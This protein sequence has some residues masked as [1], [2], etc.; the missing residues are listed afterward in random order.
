M[1]P[2]FKS[3]IEMCASFD[4]RAHLPALIVV[5][6]LAKYAKFVKYPNLLLFWCGRP[7]RTRDCANT[8]VG[9][10]AYTKLRSLDSICHC[11]R[12]VV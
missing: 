10:Y 6:L 11:D 2:R 5:V 3:D 9:A 8:E 12:N 1:I 7:R 4:K